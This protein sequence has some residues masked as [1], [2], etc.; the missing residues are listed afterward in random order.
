MTY[1]GYSARIDHDDNGGVMV[2]HIAGTSHKP[3]TTT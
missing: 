2:D 1:K 3:S